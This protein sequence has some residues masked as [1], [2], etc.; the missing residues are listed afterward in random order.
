MAEVMSM[1]KIIHAAVRRDL[2][3]FADALAKFP[4][5]NAAR[6][7]ELLAAWKFFY[8]ELDYH[9]HG[10]HDIAWPALESVGVPRATLDQMD[11]E[12]ARMADALG[13]ADTAFA[14]L[15]KAPSKSSAQDAA[16]AIASLE[17][18]VS[19]HLAHEE[20]ELEPVYQANRAGPEMKA[21]GRKFSKRNPKQAGDFFAWIQNGATAEENAA[22][23]AEVPPPVVAIFG[24]LLGRRYRRTVAPVWQ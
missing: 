1:N 22:L 19:E 17:A 24:R 6:A 20:A 7:G 18:V 12:H 10:E 9:H 15:A 23:R 11:A 14:T 21:M 4:D 2:R 5:G 3:R 13:A 16:T 8:A